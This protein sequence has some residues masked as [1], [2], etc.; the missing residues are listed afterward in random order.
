MD[1][2]ALLCF[3]LG[4]LA[5]LL[6]T[7]VPGIVAVLSGAGIGALCAYLWAQDSPWLAAGAFVVCVLLV[8]A[9]AAGGGRG[10]RGG[11]GGDLADALG[12]VVGAALD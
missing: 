3:G 4:A 11:G 7:G 10:G 6:L 12:D 9:I 1:M 5:I 8:A 2:T